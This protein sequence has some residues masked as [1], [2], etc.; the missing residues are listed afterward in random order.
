MVEGGVKRRRLKSAVDW[1]FRV[2][3]HW[4][5]S[6]PSGHHIRYV[7]QRAQGSQ[8]A[9]DWVFADMVERARRH[10]SVLGPQR[11]KLLELGAGFDFAAA[12]TLWGLGYRQ[13]VLV[14]IRRL[15]RVGLVNNICSRLRHLGL[16]APGPIETFD[17]LQRYGIE[18]RVPFDAC[19]TGIPDD[20][21]HHIVSTNVLEHIPARDIPAVLSE[22]RRIVSGDGTVSMQIDC[23]DH[24]SYQDPSLDRFNFRRYNDRTW[25]LFNPPSLY[26]NR[27]TPS[28]HISLFKSA[29][30]QIY[31]CE[32]MVPE[33][34]GVHIGARK[35]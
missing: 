20:S 28:E 25:R 15:A 3:A 21:F 10:A 13:Q 5:A 31:S 4:L 16:E 8:P 23:Q 33:G 34:A 6:G 19:D 32:F 35:R 1:R 30:F 18:Y 11:G 2:A 24:W 26:Q 14:D 7:F 22:C 12:L 9:P 29:G 17:D 27:L